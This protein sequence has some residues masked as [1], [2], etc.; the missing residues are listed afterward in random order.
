MCGIFYLRGLGLVTRTH[1]FIISSVLTRLEALAI[2]K[3]YE[4]LLKG[5]MLTS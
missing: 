4:S 2:V 3:A 5:Y 1:I